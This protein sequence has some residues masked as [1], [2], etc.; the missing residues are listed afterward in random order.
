M[1]AKDFLKLAEKAVFFVFVGTSSRFCKKSKKKTVQNYII[2]FEI[3]F[4]ENLTE[5]LEFDMPNFIKQ[6]QIPI[7]ID[8]DQLQQL[9]ILKL[10]QHDFDVSGA[11][12]K[13]FLPSTDDNNNTHT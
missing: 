12:R 10:F 3:V 9:P 11:M 4:M 7:S 2:N 5:A 8:G 6:I 1:G 13:Y